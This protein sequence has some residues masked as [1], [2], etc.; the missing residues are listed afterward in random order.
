MAPTR[1]V[2]VT[3]SLRQATSGRKQNI[4]IGMGMC[5]LGSKEALNTSTNRFEAK[6]IYEIFQRL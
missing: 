6:S 5:G 1:I 2:T 3:I 4:A